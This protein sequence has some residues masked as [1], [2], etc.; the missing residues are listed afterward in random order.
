MRPGKRVAVAPSPEWRKPVATWVE[1]LDRYI[2]YIQVPA[3]R[4]NAFTR[5]G[6]DTRPC[7]P[8]DEAALLRTKM[9]RAIDVVARRLSVPTPECIAT[10]DDLRGL[11]QFQGRHVP[12]PER[13]PK[14][15]HWHLLRAFLLNKSG[16]TCKYCSR[17]AWGVY[18][19]QAG[20]E[21]PRTLRFEMDH[22]T[23]RRKL[24]DP[25]DPANLVIACRS[26]NTIKG[27]MA[28]GRFRLELKSLAAAV[29]QTLAGEPDGLTSKWS[30]RADRP[31]PTCR[32]GARLIWRV[33]QPEHR[34]SAR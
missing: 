8:A 32:H 20:T 2:T 16:Y 17:S 12:R 1:V 27:E 34:T 4:V 21:P 10:I 14:E 9:L 22:L 31:V 25:S 3:W 26:C 24:T 6:A 13:C 28:E 18:A 5:D 29:Q 15:I 7:V 23:P 33:R 30:R 11:G 19:E